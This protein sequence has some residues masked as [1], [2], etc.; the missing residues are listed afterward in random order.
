MELIKQQFHKHNS[1]PIHRIWTNWTYTR[2][3]RSKIL[4]HR[5]HYFMK[6]WKQPFA[7]FRIIMITTIP[8]IEINRLVFPPSALRFHPDLKA[9]HFHCLNH[10]K[11]PQ[12]LRFRRNL[13][14]GECCQPSISLTASIVRII[15]FVLRLLLF[16]SRFDIILC[17]SVP[18]KWQS[19]WCVL[20]CFS[21]SYCRMFA[22]AHRKLLWLIFHNILPEFPHI[23]AELWCTRCSRD[24]LDP[25]KVN[26]DIAQEYWKA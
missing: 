9:R 26:S 12:V 25:K 4:T 21:E 11:I 23:L 19:N 5:P 16:L 17:E 8:A 22:R 24:R 18:T 15:H 3:W 10:K 6:L 7:T 20:L 14:P 1:L 2:F 13:V